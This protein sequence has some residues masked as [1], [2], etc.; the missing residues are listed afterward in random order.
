MPDVID[1]WRNPATAIAS[2]ALAVALVGTGI[3]VLAVLDNGTPGPRGEQGPPGPK[4]DT[5]ERGAGGGPLKNLNDLEGTPCSANGTEGTTR[6]I[7][8]VEGNAVIVCGTTQPAPDKPDDTAST[9]TSLV[10]NGKWTA[11]EISPAGEDVDYWRVKLSLCPIGRRCTLRVVVRR[12]G[13]TPGAIDKG[14]RVTLYSNAGVTLPVIA[15]KSALDPEITVEAN[16][17]SPN[18]A[19]AVSIEWAPTPSGMFA[20]FVY[21]ISATVA[22]D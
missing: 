6:L 19:V 17:L 20:D 4:G 2:I 14:M 10:P 13:A 5:G 21:E 11:G 22:P 7:F 8:T 3:A 12:P 15:E 9:G 16:G 1:G 18:D